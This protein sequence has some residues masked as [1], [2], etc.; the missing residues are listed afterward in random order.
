MTT[1]EL[2]R[3]GKTGKQEERLRGGQPRCYE[4]LDRPSDF[5]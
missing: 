4:H 1:K 2:Q 5:Q 3:G